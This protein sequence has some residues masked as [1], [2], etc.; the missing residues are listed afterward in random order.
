MTDMDVRLVSQLLSDLSNFL[1][2]PV[3]RIESTP[4]D[5]IHALRDELEKARKEKEQAEF[6]YEQLVVQYGNEV[7]RVLRL[8]DL[9]KEYHIKWR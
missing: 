2:N 7:T 4:S 3:I 8:Q 9:C 1:R 5:D 6:K